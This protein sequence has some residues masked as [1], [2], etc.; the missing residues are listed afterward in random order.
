MIFP[1][2]VLVAGPFCARRLATYTSTGLLHSGQRPSLGAANSAVIASGSRRFSAQTDVQDNMLSKPSLCLTSRSQH[3]SRAGSWAAW[4]RRP[5]RAAATKEPQPTGSQPQPVK[6]VVPLADAKGLW[7]LNSMEETAVPPHVYGDSF[8]I[9]RA[10]A[11]RPGRPA[12]T[13]TRTKTRALARPGALHPSSAASL[14]VQAFRKQ[15]SSVVL[16]DVPLDVEVLDVGFDVPEEQEPQ[17]ALPQAVT[18]TSIVRVE[19]A[20]AGGLVVCTTPDVV[21]VQLESAQVGRLRRRRGRHSGVVALAKAANELL[22]PRAPLLG[23]S[24]MPIFLPP[25]NQP[26]GGA[27]PAGVPA[28]V[29]G[30]GGDAGPG[31]FETSSASPRRTCKVK[32]TCN[33]CKATNIKPIN[34]VAFREGTVFARCALSQRLCCFFAGVS[35][36]MALGTPSAPSSS[37]FALM[38]RHDP[39]A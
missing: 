15:P 6:V 12:S 18:T 25:F 32:F 33:I 17:A 16:Y 10:A 21:D 24:L 31:V 38:M 26:Q 36:S 30:G 20:A 8:V 7:F 13:K 1:P 2:T 14:A 29:S 37:P 4:A 27:P 19:A 3:A 23:S 35:F 22:E 11:A 9:R 34:P 5:T 28:A 39:R